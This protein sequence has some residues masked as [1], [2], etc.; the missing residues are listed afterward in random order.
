MSPLGLFSIDG[1]LAVALSLAGLL[2]AIAAFRH[3]TDLR[4]E[5]ERLRGAVLVLQS[6]QVMMSGEQFSA[7]GLEAVDAAAGEEIREL[8]Q[9]LKEAKECTDGCFFQRREKD[10]A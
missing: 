5:N 6:A 9:S 3:L 2:A 8:F 4:R 1:R 10:T 7:A